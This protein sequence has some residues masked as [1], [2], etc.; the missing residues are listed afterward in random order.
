MAQTPKGGL[1]GPPSQGHLG[2]CAIYSETT[3]GGMTR[4]PLH[5][6]PVRWRAAGAGR[7]WR[8]RARHGGR[9]DLTNR[10]ASVAK[11]AKRS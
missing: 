7:Q 3:F 6:H 8:Q 4:P 9:S 5:Y 11:P 1:Y 10:E 2:V